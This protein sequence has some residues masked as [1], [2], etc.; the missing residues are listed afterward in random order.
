MG[1]DGTDAV[2]EGPSSLKS[3]VLAICLIA[4]P[5]ISE[6]SKVTNKHVSR[7]NMLQL[8]IRAHISRSDC[9]SRFDAN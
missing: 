8:P 9:P 5:G 7:L 6:F 1:L 2:K 3:Q 4:Q